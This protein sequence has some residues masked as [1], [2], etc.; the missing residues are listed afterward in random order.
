M[1]SLEAYESYLSLVNKNSTNSNVKIP[2]GRFVQMFNREAKR[3]LQERLRQEAS[4][5]DKNELEFLLFTDIPLTKVRDTVRYSEFV[6]PTD[7]FKYETSYSLASKNDVKNRV[8]HNW[9]FKDKNT[10]VLLQDEN[11]NPSF[12]FEET[13][14]KL[15][16]GKL[17]VYKSNFNVDE[18][19]ATYYKNPQDIDIRGYIKLDGIDSI[20]LD[21]QFPDRITDQIISRCAIETIR[22]YENPDG[23]QLAKDRINT[24]K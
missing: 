2:K 8:L 1:T 22:S 21:P 3:L 20:N 19:Y 16:S 4:I 9:D 23:F 5:D 14:V 13:L 7:N 6:L 24:E 18:V 12:E 15:S 10:E 11:Y 17:L